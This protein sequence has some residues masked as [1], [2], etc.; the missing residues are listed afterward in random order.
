MLVV[1]EFGGN[2]EYIKSLLVLLSY[3][4]YVILVLGGGWAE[5]ERL[6]PSQGSTSMVTLATY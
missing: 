1:V 2:D 6:I 5:R 4:E 3:S